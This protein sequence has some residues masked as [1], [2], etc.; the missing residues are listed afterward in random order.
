MKIKN[1]DQTDETILNLLIENSRMSY[2]EISEK[3]GLSRISVK[4]RI[5]A[6]EKAGII[7][8]YTIILNPEKIGRNASVFFEIEADP[9]H[10]S[11]IIDALNAEDAVTDLY[12]MTGS[13]NLH[14]HAVLGMDE[15]LESFL[16]D[17]IYKLP[18]IR[19]VKSDLIV[20]RLKTRKGIRI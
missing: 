14:V 17:K 6:L 7:E 18:G 19:K 8:Q 4:N 1:C 15:S 11:A 12:L 9:T 20:S 5:E 16:L 2:I 13:T 3:T 10:L